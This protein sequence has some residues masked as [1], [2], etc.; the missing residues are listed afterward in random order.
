M[1]DQRL[2]GSDLYVARLCRSETKDRPSSLEC[3][4]AQRDVQ[5]GAK[6]DLHSGGDCQPVRS[7]TGSLHD[8]LRFCKPKRSQSSAHCSRS[9]LMK[10]MATLSRPCYRCISYMYSAGIK[11]VFWT[12]SKGEWEG[13]KVQELVDA[14]AGNGRGGGSDTNSVFVTKHEV[15]MLKKTTSQ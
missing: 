12:N 3:N 15:L 9:Q 13:A 8:E 5:N 14:L 7:L 4:K 2:R 10:P 11:R 6:T 1:K